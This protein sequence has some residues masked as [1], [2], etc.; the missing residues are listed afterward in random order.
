MLLE[1]LVTAIETVK[2]RIQA[3]RQT[4]QK[5]E[6]HTR[7]ALIDPILQSLGWDTTDPSLIQPEY[8]VDGKRADYA[9][10]NLRGNPALF[11]EA[12]SLGTNLRGNLTQMVNYAIA[13]GVP[14]VGITD[15]DQWEVYEVFDPRPLEEK[16]ILSASIANNPTHQCALELLLLWRPNIASSQPAQVNRPVLHE[17]TVPP[18][19]VVAQPAAPPASEINR[20][21]E[22]IGISPKPDP[23]PPSYG[24][25]PLT[26]L[27]AVQGEKPPPIVRL[28]NG[29][30]RPLRAWNSLLIE[31]AEWL[32]REGALTG[33]GCPVSLRANSKRYIVHWESRHLSGRDFRR[34]HPLSNGLFLETNYS[35]RSIVDGSKALMEKFGQDPSLVLLKTG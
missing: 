9:L 21:N 13:D 20:A 10:L 16:R 19:T 26:S 6:T 35:A 29:E 27:T 3:H 32:I 24:Y 4:L 18:P 11:L 8:N 33:A 1:S 34:I 7:M 5:N 23:I 30:E 28:P 25:T 14:Y 2:S 15:G 22:P 12:K 31:V 17:E